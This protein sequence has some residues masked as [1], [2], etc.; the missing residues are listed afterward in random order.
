MTIQKWTFFLN[1]KMYPF[2]KSFSQCSFQG[3][4]H[5][6]VSF[7]FQFTYHENLSKNIRCKV[8]LN[9]HQMYSAI[10]VFPM[11]FSRLRPFKNEFS[12]SISQIHH[13]NCIQISSYVCQRTFCNTFLWN[14]SQFKVLNQALKWSKKSKCTQ[15]L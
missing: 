9:F 1:S 10:I 13:I 8:S 5:L 6:K 15:T 3:W 4:S 7:Q 12:S 14:N 2:C 11:Q